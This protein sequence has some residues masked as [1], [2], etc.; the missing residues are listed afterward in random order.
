M[1]GLNAQGSLRDDAV[2]DQIEPHLAPGGIKYTTVA[3]QNRGT[4]AASTSGD[5]Y[6]WGQNP[7][8]P[9]RTRTLAIDS[10]QIVTLGGGSRARGACGMDAARVAYCWGTMQLVTGVPSSAHA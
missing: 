10:I 2:D 1:L 8:G 9:I 5:V 6:C 7:F 3:V 4:C